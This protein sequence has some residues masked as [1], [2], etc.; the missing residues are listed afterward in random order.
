MNKEDFI[1]KCNKCKQKNRI[2][3]INIKGINKCAKCKNI[4]IDTIEKDSIKNNSIFLTQL[5]KD[6]KKLEQKY[7]EFLKIKDKIDNKFFEIEAPISYIEDTANIDISQEDEDIIKKIKSNIG[8][9]FLYKIKIY[10]NFG[11]LIECHNNILTFKLS[12]LFLKQFRRKKENLEII[13]SKEDN[14]NFNVKARQYIEKSIRIIN[15]NVIYKDK[16]KSELNVKKSIQNISIKEE[17]KT[18]LI[19]IW[20][21]LSKK[22]HDENAEDID[23]N[24]VNKILEIIENLKSFNSPKKIKLTILED[25]EI[26]ILKLG[27]KCERELLLDDISSEKRINHKLQEINKEKNK[28]YNLKEVNAQSRTKK[29][30]EI[31]NF[32]T[33]NNQEFYDKYPDYFKNKNII[34]ELKKQIELLEKEKKKVIEIREELGKL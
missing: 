34:L 1:I 3:K 32:N 8:N 16:G 25:S 21:R 14:N 33:Q 27:L 28:Y 15:Q 5:E 7:K 31:D 17:N 24:K 19:D 22:I 4:L 23:K 29:R 6:N 30:K 11:V 9:I 10:H 26:K 12:N 18:K 13:S 2:K 20:N